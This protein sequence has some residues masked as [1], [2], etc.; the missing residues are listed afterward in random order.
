MPQAPVDGLNHGQPHQTSFRNF[1]EGERTPLPYGYTLQQENMYRIYPA[2][3]PGILGEDYEAPKN[4][5]PLNAVEV[6][7]STTTMPPGEVANPVVEVLQNQ[8]VAL[9]AAATPPPPSMEPDVGLMT[10]PGTPGPAVAAPSSNNFASHSPLPGASLETAIELSDSDD[11]ENQCLGGVAAKHR[12]ISPLP[13]RHREQQ[14]GKAAA[15]VHTH[16]APTLDDDIRVK[17]ESSE[18]RMRLQPTDKGRKRAHDDDLPS[19]LEGSSSKRQ[20]VWVQSPAPARR[21]PSGS[22]DH[23]PCRGSSPD[24]V[25][26][27]VESTRPAASGIPIP[28]P[29]DCPSWL[30][31]LG[32][33]T[34]EEEYRRRHA[35]QAVGPAFLAGNRLVD[36]LPDDYE[37]AA[38][39]QTFAAPDR[40][41]SATFMDVRRW[42]LKLKS[43][44]TLA[45]EIG[46]RRDTGG[47]LSLCDL[48]GW[49]R[50][51]ISAGYDEA[52][53][54]SGLPPLTE[55]DLPPLLR[56][57]VSTATSGW[58]SN[59]YPFR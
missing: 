44:V 37:K 22:D 17:V 51:P 48:P 6:M 31:D 27:W 35:N 23:H 53:Q 5:V 52:H 19:M 3:R 9:A 57:S 42:G 8:L 29:L 24:A 59:E 33:I 36:D 14:K 16:T 4:P 10:P 12:P 11:E 41:A 49:I 32:S 38:Q 50:A 56:Q 46:Y 20:R 45:G 18:E 15:I 13:A 34:G 47:R 2:T 1:A 54:K 30:H 28:P 58:V 43:G 21:S 7:L 55:L 39:Q 40:R 25:R 26:A